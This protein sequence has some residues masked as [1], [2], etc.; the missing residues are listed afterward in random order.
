V[1]LLREAEL[2]LASEAAPP[3][4]A[5]SAARVAAQEP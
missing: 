5:V 3:E 1:L 2:V 4:A